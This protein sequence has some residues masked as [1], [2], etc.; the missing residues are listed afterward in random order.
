MTKII[1]LEEFKKNRLARMKEKFE[2]NATV[3]QAVQKPPGTP[4]KPLTYHLLV[5]ADHETRLKYRE[6]MFDIIIRL[7]L[8]MTPTD[9][10]K[11]YVFFIRFPVQDV[12]TF[13]NAY[14]ECAVMWLNVI[15][16]LREDV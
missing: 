7:G 10:R 15:Q 4:D 2:T 16:L 12:I 1:D 11:L 5:S 13:Y 8:P 14:M 6:Q 3:M 9:K